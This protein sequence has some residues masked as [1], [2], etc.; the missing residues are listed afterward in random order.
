MK[1][2]STGWKLP[3]FIGVLVIVALLINIF[4]FNKA[5]AHRE[6]TAQEQRQ[7][8]AAAEAKQAAEKLAQ[9]KKDAE[10][11][12]QQ[13]AKAAEAKRN[14][15]EA[16]AKAQAEEARKKAIEDAAAEH[17]QFLARYL[18]PGFTHRP[19]LATIAVVIESEQGTMNLAVANA[20]MQRLA[21]GDVQLLNSFFKPEFVADK[22]VDN[23]FSGD[24]SVFD[25][26]NLTN[27]VDGVLFGRETIT[28][29]TNI[30][31]ENTIS[32]DLHLGVIVLP[33]ATAQSGLSWSIS[34]TGVGFNN[35]AARQQAEE[36]LI[37]Q[38]ADDSTMSL[39]K[40]STKR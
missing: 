21:N 29:S 23:I 2:P 16:E 34:A 40:F 10:E 7:A 4:F 31:L 39:S 37:R 1:S 8:A 32:A 19:G 25:R 14:R 30:A 35:T 27:S 22:F 12:Q 18:N 36:R 6:A 24:T 17:A 20:V 11:A 26:L 3:V 5:A 38:I 9:D 28:Y 33:L 15:D 13:A